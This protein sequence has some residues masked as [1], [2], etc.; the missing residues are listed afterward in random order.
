MLSNTRPDVLGSQCIELIM[1]RLNCD[2]FFEICGEQNLRN[3]GTGARAWE[4]TAN[5]RQNE[6][7]VNPSKVVHHSCDPNAEDGIGMGSEDST[8]LILSGRMR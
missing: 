7:H 3:F 6:D 2:C 1:W 5:E 8:C 4:G